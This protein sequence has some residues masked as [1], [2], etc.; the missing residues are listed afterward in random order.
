M[1]SYNPQKNR[2]AFQK[3]Y[4]YEIMNIGYIYN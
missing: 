4:L 3:K 2:Y 1:E